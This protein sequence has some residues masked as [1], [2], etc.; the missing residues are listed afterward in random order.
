MTGPTLTLYAVARQLGSLQNPKRPKTADAE[1]LGL[2]KS[3][4]LGAG[5]EFPGLVT[6]WVPI[7]ATYWMK[8]GSDKFHRIRSHESR[9]YKVRL[10]SFANEYLEAIRND[11][12]AATACQRLDEL[13]AALKVASRQ[14]EVV[15]REQDWRD[16]KDRH[17]PPD[18]GKTGYPRGAPQKRGWSHFFPIA[19]GYM[20]TLPGK[21]TQS[22]E[23]VAAAIL[24]LA[25]DEKCLDLP[26]NETLIDKIAE[27]FRWYGKLK[28]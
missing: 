7:P 24:Q 20:M 18:Q 4:A 14:Y 1:L 27:A 25:S 28:P 21:S 15:I 16:Y 12:R 17:I 9:A 6:R 13:T 3:G 10:D 19:A 5:F 11:E 8:V 26:G 23:A 22:H 2:L